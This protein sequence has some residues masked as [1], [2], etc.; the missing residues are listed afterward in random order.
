MCLLS[1]FAYLGVAADLN[2]ICKSIQSHCAAGLTLVR[3]NDR[4]VVFFV[5]LVAATPQPRYFRGVANLSLRASSQ[6]SKND[7]P[8]R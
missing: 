2:L 4:T 1:P 8:N 3:A 7:A 6:V 5:A